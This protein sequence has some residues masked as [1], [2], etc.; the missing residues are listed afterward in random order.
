MSTKYTAWPLVGVPL[1]FAVLLSRPGW[2]PLLLCGVATLLPVAPWSGRNL[3]YTGNPL[4]PL[5]ISVFGPESARGGQLH[6]YFDSFAGQSHGIS[7]ILLAPLGYA[8]HL[9]M[10]KY[11]ISLLGLGAAFALLAIQIAKRGPVR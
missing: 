4:I 8:R 6:G 11:T 2:V 3:V 7:A 5:M 10:Q 9:I 1:G